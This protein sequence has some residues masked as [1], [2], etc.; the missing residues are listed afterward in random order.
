MERKKK[1]M[2]ISAFK[3]KSRILLVLTFGHSDLNILSY[4][5]PFDTNSILLDFWLEDQ[6][7]VEKELIWERYDFFKMT[8]EFYRQTGFVKK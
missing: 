2:E 1:R 6:M 5:S 8:Y 3:V 7:A 4:R